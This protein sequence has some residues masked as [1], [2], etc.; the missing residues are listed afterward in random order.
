MKGIDICCQQGDIDWKKVKASGVDFVIPR[1]GRGVNLD[2]NGMDW[3]FL[4]YVEG[5]QS[6]GIKVTGIYH[7]IYVHCLEDALKNAQKA[8]ENA[9]R[10]NLPKETIIWCDQEEQTVIDAVKHGFNLTTDL[11]LKVAQIF[12]NHVLAEGYCTGIYLN[13]DYYKRVYGEDIAKQ[14]DIWLCDLEDTSGIPCLYRQNDWYSRINGIETNVDTDVYVGTYTAG[15]AKGEKTVLKSKT[16]CK[17]AIALIDRPCA[18]RNEFPWNCGLLDVNGVTWGDCWN[19]NPKTMIWSMTIGEPVWDNHVVGADHVRHVVGDGISATGLG[20]YGGDYIMNNYCTETTFRRMLEAKK[21]P[22]LL[23]I[24]GHHMGAYVGDFERDGKIYNVSE[25]SP[26]D[27]LGGKMR[28]Y[29]DEYG[30]R[31]THKNGY[32]IGSW[33]RCGYLTK[34]LDYSDWDNP[35]PP[36]PTPVPSVDKLAQEIYAGKWGNNP[37]RRNK[38]VAQYGEDMYNKAQKR[39]DQMVTGMNWY[40]TEV[41]LAR[42]ILEGKWGNNPNRQNN[43]TLKYGADAYRIAQGFVNS[44]VAKDYTLDNLERA[45]DVAG[46]ILC[47]VYGNNPQR[48]QTIVSKYGEKVYQ[49]AQGFV[50]QIMG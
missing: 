1:D 21:A 50:N 28:S 5:A 13:K 26:N 31:M 38:I 4:E 22:C 6:V 19:I 18:Y 36:K 49:L 47:N 15:T 37:E 41:K 11:Q 35:E 12:C 8:V 42:E 16:Y 14:Y 9:R 34:Y 30:R 7:F 48:R 3:N 25:F 2:D 46:G 24:N 39:V 43:I 44:I 20:D 33:N 45:Y 17:G 40:R 27:N 32:A 10:A 29:V 23:L